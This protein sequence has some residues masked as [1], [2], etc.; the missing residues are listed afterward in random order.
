M[1]FQ[2]PSMLTALNP[3]STRRT[4]PV[5]TSGNIN[6]YLS[7][8]FRPTTNETE[9]R[10]QTADIHDSSS[11]SSY[12]TDSGSSSDFKFFPDLSYDGYRILPA[13]PFIPFPLSSSKPDP[14]L[15]CSICHKV[16]PR[17]YELGRYISFS[18]IV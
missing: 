1:Q 3:Q 15:T 13:I 17:I 6:T 18:Y 12:T 9:M 4:P 5:L 16:F 2:Y 14:E 10:C 7:K 8:P 11:E